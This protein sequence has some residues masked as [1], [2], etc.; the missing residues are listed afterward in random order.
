MERFASPASRL[1]CTL[2][3]GNTSTIALDQLGCTTMFVAVRLARTLC[4]AES[5]DAVLCVTS[6]FAP[7]ETGREEIFNC[8]SDA[9]CAVLVQRGGDRGRIVGGAHGTKGYYWDAGRKRDEI[10][11]SYFPT[12]R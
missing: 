2:D 6:D 10:I 4:L 11:A 8:T 7:N 12:A 3:L 5:M 1:Q 9:A